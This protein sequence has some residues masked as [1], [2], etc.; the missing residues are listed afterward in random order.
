MV[1]NENLMKSLELENEFFKSENL[2]LKSENNSKI[3]QIEEQK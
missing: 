1:K 3:L 2:K